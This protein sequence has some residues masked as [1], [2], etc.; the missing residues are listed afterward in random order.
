MR[1]HILPDEKIINRTIETFETVFPGENKFVIISSTGTRRYVKEDTDTVILTTYDTDKFWESVG[2][3]KQYQSIIVHLMTKYSASFINRIDHDNIFWIEWGVDLFD[4]LLEPRGFKMFYDVDVMYRYVYPS[5]KRRLAHKYLKFLFPDK[6]RRNAIKKV[7]Y[8]VPDSMYD[9]FPLLL[10]YYPQYSH[11]EYREFFYYPINQVVDDTIKDELCHGSNIIV[12]NSGSFTGN[13][14]EVIDILSKI[15]LG[16]RKVKFS[17]CYGGSKEYRDDVI[18]V[19]KQKLKETFEAIT[20][21]MPLA[22][23]NK[24]LLDATFYIY[25]NY[26][27]EAVGNIL[28]ALYFGGKVFLS[29]NSPLLTFYQNMGLIIFPVSTISEESLSEGLTPAEIRK[30]RELIEIHYSLERLY[31]LVK[32]NFT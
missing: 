12:G 21:Y 3:V 6:N 4:N 29:D 30:N 9:E 7:K 8:F 10:K 14:F 5:I 26:R 32:E 24:F 13:H 23:Y 16:E 15:K 27:Q 11:L 2:D 28:V 22:E 25:N 17:L 20:D 19:G 1:L 31:R 18:K